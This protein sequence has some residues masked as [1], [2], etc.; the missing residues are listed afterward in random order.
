[1]FQRNVL[2]ILKSTFSYNEEFLYLG[3]LLIVLMWNTQYG[4]AHLSVC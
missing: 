3:E 4:V 1:M 2:F